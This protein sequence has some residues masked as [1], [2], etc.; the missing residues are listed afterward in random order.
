MLRVVALAVSLAAV[1]PAAAIAASKPRAAKASAVPALT[2]RATPANPVSVQLVRLAGQATGVAPGTAVQLYKSAYPYTVSQ[3][4]RT[5]AIGPT[6]SFAFAVWPDRDVRY[7]A[8]VAA[9]NAQASIQLN[10]AGRT[11][12]QIR[13]LTLGRARVSMLVWHPA[14]LRWG[15]ALA[16]WSF[17]N[18]GARTLITSRTLDLSPNLLLLSATVALPAGHY[19]WTAC[20]H[21]PGDHALANSRRPPGCTGRGYRGG[22][23]LPFGFPAPAAVSGAAAYLAGRLGR[24]AFAVVDSEGRLSGIHVHWTFPTASVVKA[25][26]LVAYLRRLDAMGRRTVDPYS[27]SF[28]YPMI[29]VSDN[30][31]ATQCWSIV[32]DGGLYAVAGAAGMTDFSVSG[33]WG[34]ALLSPADQARFFFEMD[35]LIPHEFV[36][37]ARYLLST[38]IGWQTWAI[39]VVAR[40]LG[41]SVFFK[42]GSEPTALGQLV[43]QV[44]RLEGHGR[45]IAVA[46]MTDGD[47]TMQYGIDTIEGVARALLG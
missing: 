16:R 21:A 14:D 5:A 35:S 37:Y 41:Y 46:V 6:G 47:P 38:I 30:N 39:P 17:T 33:S 12:T 31:A 7:R 29:H 44:A 20:F 43:H 36:G 4:V 10:V 27:N 45:K 22:G 1:L 2:L 34:T 8:V 42:D 25:M 18:G 32:G 15:K 23:Y 26:C 19:T 40:P 9:A 28:L 24:T 13:A 3:L 11:Q